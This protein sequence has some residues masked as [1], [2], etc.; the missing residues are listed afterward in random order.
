MSGIFVGLSGD[1][2]VGKSRVADYLVESFGFV[3]AH[4][5]FG[6]K[7]ATR[8][9]FQH[10]G[11]T[12]EESHRMTDGDLKDIPSPYLPNNALPRYFMEEFG[13]FMG[14][15]LGPEWTIGVEMDKIDQA[16]ARAGRD[17]RVIMESIVYEIDYLRG[18]TDALIVKVER[19]QARNTIDA[20]RTSA[21]G[22][23][24]V[25]DVTLHNN[26]DDLSVLHAAIDG[27][28]LERFNIERDPV[29]QPDF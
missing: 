29:L 24:I 6:G 13:Y 3:R 11:A 1:R 8:A 10:L 25:P 17:S 14:S 26:G 22:K 23:L 27:I 19:D 9:Y 2:Q 7:I 28:M 18:R 4:P 21:A 16:S 12:E 5:F 15:G 20:P